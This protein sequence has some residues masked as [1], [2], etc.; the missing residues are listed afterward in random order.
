MVDEFRVIGREPGGEIAAEGA[1]DHVAGTR[2]HL[3]DEFADDTREPAH[4]LHCAVGARTVEPGNHRNVQR[5]RF[6]EPFEHARPANAASRVQIEDSPAL[7]GNEVREFSGGER[8][9][10][11]LHPSP[12]SEIAHVRMHPV[13]EQFHSAP[14]HL[15]GKG[16]DFDGK[17]EYAVAQ[18]AVD[19]LDLFDHGL[20]A[21]AEHGA[22]VYRLIERQRA[23]L[24][25]AALP[26]V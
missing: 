24:V 25:E 14:D 4:R 10:A 22:A 7:A 19:A 17:V 12:P 23:A 18:L 5:E 13:A 15:V 1:A 6:C 9:L 16:P 8:N 20:G 3:L 26:A 21:A 2:Y 11:R